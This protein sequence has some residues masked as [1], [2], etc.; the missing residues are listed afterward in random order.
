M[1][2]KC[3]GVVKTLFE[4]SLINFVSKTQYYWNLIL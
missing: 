4:S 1:K 2:I 3:N